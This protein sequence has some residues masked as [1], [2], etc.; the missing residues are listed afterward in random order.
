MVVTRV[1]GWQLVF[2]S[3]RQKRCPSQKV[4]FACMKNFCPAKKW[5]PV[6]ASARTADAVTNAAPVPEMKTGIAA[7]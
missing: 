2:I 3:R 7:Q 1:L 6:S 5:I 4:T